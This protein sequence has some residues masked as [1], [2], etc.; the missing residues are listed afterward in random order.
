MPYH[1]SS[2]Y[3]GSGNRQYGNRDR[4]DCRSREETQLDDQ[5]LLQSFYDGDQLK[6]EVFR[7]IPEN[8][9]EQFE[10]AGMKSTSIRR[11]YNVVRQAY[12][13]YRFDPKHN[14]SPSKELIESLDHLVVYSQSRDVTKSCFTKFVKHYIELAAQNPQNLRA[15]KKHFESVIGFMKK[16]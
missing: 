14:F 3:G 11:F 1:Q 12:D 10:E 9:A 4:K 8:I 6:S 13:R 5:L 16:K 15:F 2:N 7:G